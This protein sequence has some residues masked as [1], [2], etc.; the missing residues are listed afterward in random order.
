MPLLVD[1]HND[2]A[3]NMLVF[4]RDYRRPVEETRRLEE[5]SRVR[6]FS[7]DTLIGWPEYQRGQVAVVFATL[8]APPM[9][10]AHNEMEVPFGYRTPDE[11]R[12]LYRAQ[13]DLYHRLADSEPESFRLVTTGRGLEEVLEHWKSGSHSSANSDHPM[14]LVLL[15]EGADGIRLPAD[16]EEWFERG[17]RV[18]GPAWVGTRYTGGWKEPGP[19][20]EDG[21][22]LLAAMADYNFILDLSH[23]DEP[24][25]LEALDLYPGPVVATH[26]NCAALLPD[27]PNNRH[28]SD[29]VISGVIERDGVVGVVPYNGYLKVG[30]TQGAGRREEVPLSVLVDHIDHICQLAGDSLH[31]GI[32]S[33]FDGGFGLQSVPP[34]ID[35]IADLQKIG[36][37]LVQRGYSEA[38]A[39][40]ILGGNWI[41]RLRRDLPPR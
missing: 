10:Q 21:R 40:N 24:A 20:T 37:Q 8:F 31:A 28:F 35:S 23:M 39:A 32:G 16:L 13:L 6:Q 4:G 17:L 1:S 33:D 41:T 2:I 12:R 14:G 9:R 29:R 15:M 27:F 22:R 7:E 18:I 25:S 30:W 11:A 36:P 26:G 19:L 3:W 38:D 34:E 5:G